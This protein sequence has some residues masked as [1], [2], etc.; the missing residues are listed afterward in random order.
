MTWIVTPAMGKCNLFTL[1]CIPHLHKVPAAHYVR[2]PIKSHCVV[3]TLHLTASKVPAALLSKN[4]YTA[5]CTPYLTLGVSKA[6]Q[7]FLRVN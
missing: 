7:Q 5:V 3:S 2:I 6:F 1:T 4:A